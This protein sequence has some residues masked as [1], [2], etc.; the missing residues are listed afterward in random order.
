MTAKLDNSSFTVSFSDYIAHVGGLRS[1]RQMLESVELLPDDV[2]WEDW[3]YP[4][5]ETALL[6][7]FR[8]RLRKVTPADLI[9]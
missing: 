8:F 9:S 7:N 2:P 4:K 1:F 6:Q 5:L 3:M